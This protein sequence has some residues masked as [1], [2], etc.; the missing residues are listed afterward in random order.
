[1]I[2][3][4]IGFR[5]LAN[6]VRTW[7][8]GM[9]K[10]DTLGSAAFEDAPFDEG[11]F[12]EGSWQ[13]ELFSADTLEQHG[14][15]I[16]AAHAL[17]EAGAPERLLKRLERNAQILIDAHGTLTAAVRAHDQIAPAGEWL[18]DNFYL[19]DTQIRTARLHLPKSY[20]RALPCLAQGPS[21]GLPRVYDIALESIRHC[22]GLLDQDTL[23]R[24]VTA[25]Q[26]ITPLSLGE[27]W[28]IPIMLRLALIENLTRVAARLVTARLHLARAQD[29]A[30]RMMETAETD[31]KSLVL[32]IADMARSNPPLESP[33]VAELTRRLRGHG[34]AL[35]LP[36]SWI[37]QRL[38]ESSLTIEQLVL[39]DNQR[40][41]A[42]QVSISNSIGSLRLLEAI[43]WRV[44]VET[45]SFV[46]RALQDDPGDAYRQMDFATRDRYRHVVAD[47]AR[48]SPLDEVEVARK[49]IELAQRSAVVDIGAAHRAHVGYYLIDG[50]LP[51]LEREVQATLS[52]GEL[53]LR[54]V[55][56]V[57]LGCYVGTIA[58]L[59]ALFAVLLL[60]EAH[61][62]GVATRWLLALA[63]LAPLG[64]SQLASTL[65]NCLATVL[66]KPRPL[67]RMDFSHGLPAE[68]RTLCVVP[69]M[70]C[71]TDAIDELLES[72]EVRF[73]GN[74]DRNLHFGL[75]TDFRDATEAT[76][77]EDDLLLQAVQIG[78]EKLNA[79]Y[80]G[81]GDDRF[82]LFHRP[83]RWNPAER[84]WMG[85]E[86]KRGKLAELNLLL[87]D[88][89]SGCFSTIVGNVAVLSGIRYV[90]TL[91]TDTLLPRDVA[92]QLVGAMAHPLN[93]PRFDEGNQ[94]VSGGYGILQPR[95]AFCLSGG[96][97]S[98]YSDLGCNEPGIDPYTRSV[99]DVY[100]DLFNEGSFIG[101]GI[102]DVDAFER[103]L[104][105][106][107]PEN[108]ILSHDL[109]EGCYAR[110]GLLS[111]VCLFEAHP[112]RYQFDM[113]RQRRWIRGD[114]QIAQWTLPCVP[115]P[116]GRR[117]RNPL[118]LLSRW[119]ILDNLRRSLAAAALVSL[120][121]FGWILVPAPWLW[122]V[123]ILG[124]FLIPPCCSLPWKLCADPL[125]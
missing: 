84:Q 92:R 108:R 43:D 101:K 35:A 23:A 95:M 77:P 125:A 2:R 49:A 110:S 80:S 54:R 82:F 122:T 111:D 71:S 114:W 115:G 51:E 102:Y 99:S 79:R 87:R 113:H 73:L 98:R 75:L 15:T 19:I 86:R 29:W 59:T 65:T 76:L 17:C 45:M 47:L 67:P 109:L 53:L 1:M 88:R 57:P 70:I 44:F 83:R 46:E 58:I 105:A 91:D 42:E 112:A 11:S 100:Q 31:P 25:Y 3:R 107:L 7:T 106:R 4:E 119:K 56:R 72:L 121:L 60:L 62:Q 5:N 36:L 61:A 78:I 97:R 63:I 8:R 116:N 38:A 103:V 41:A 13:A 18:L 120:L 9:G 66:I 33:F 12:D 39:L 37:E 96:R 40:Q 24:F 48:R 104:Q 85:Y 81:Q 50:G 117:L 52:T 6:A 22:D 124:I 26:A 64:V 89:G 10:P 16:A 69:S 123:A 27:L 14:G 74:R 68:L 94:R 118:S 28:A 30:N 20:S 21:A 32:V 90:I 55:S 93:R 34:L